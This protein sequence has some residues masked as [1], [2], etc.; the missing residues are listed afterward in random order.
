MPYFQ[1]LSRARN[2]MTIC[3]AVEGCTCCFDIVTAG[4]GSVST[5]QPPGALTSDIIN[6][7]CALQAV[8]RSLQTYTLGN[9]S[10]LYLIF[11]RIHKIFFVYLGFILPAKHVD[12]IFNMF[13]YCYLFFI[14]FVLYIRFCMRCVVILTCDLL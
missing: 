8:A 11:P 1:I 9:K 10:R 5:D 2:L 4:A 14:T 7:Q 3:C 12:C 13:Y 6:Y